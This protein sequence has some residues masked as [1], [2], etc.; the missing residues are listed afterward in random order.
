MSSPFTTIY[1]AIRTK[2]LA[3][4][5]EVKHV[6]LDYGQLKTYDGRPSVQ[7]PC[8]LIDFIGWQFSNIGENA[9]IAEGQ[10]VITVGF[11]Q[12]TRTDGI[13][14]DSMLERGLEY[15]EIEQAMCEQFH[16]WAPG[17]GFGYLIRQAATT[18]NLPNGIR[19]RVVSFVLEFEDY[20]L[21]RLYTVG[22]KPLPEISTT[23]V[24]IIV[25]AP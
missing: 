14:T 21:A 1:K 23:S 6:N 24:D 8:V 12:Y 25:P 18:V 4:M 13:A 3:D 5:P 2:I 17:D 7:F 20:S 16:G 19:T 9:Q 22:A 11:A 15:M 10:V